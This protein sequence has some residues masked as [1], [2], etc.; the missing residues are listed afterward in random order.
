MSELTEDDIICKLCMRNKTDTSCLIL[1]HWKHRFRYDF[2]T[3][4]DCWDM[5][6]NAITNTNGVIDS[7]K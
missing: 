3:C 4:I 1:M 2:Y 7:L 6:Q 5:M